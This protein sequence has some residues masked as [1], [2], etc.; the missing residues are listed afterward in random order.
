M[1]RILT[2]AQMRE[3]DRVTIEERGVLG[4]ILMENAGAR[5]YELLAHRFSPLNSQRIVILCG[6]GNNGGDGL[7]VAR[8]ILTR[9]NGAGLDVVLLADPADLKGDAEANYRMLRAVGGDPICVRDSTDWRARRA[10]FLDA[11]VVV[12]A[13]LGTGLRGPAEGLPLEVIRDVNANFRRAS[14]VAVDMPSA[15]AASSSA[16]PAK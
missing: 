14:V 8:Q 2:A 7:V 1:Q 10:G 16:R 4:L 5:V 15:V 6:K 13:I 3:V 11:T 9:G 12:D